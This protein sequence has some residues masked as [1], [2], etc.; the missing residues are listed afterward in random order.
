AKGGAPVRRTGHVAELLK[1]AVDL[2]RAG[3][4]VG[5]HLSIGAGLWASEFDPGQM[6]QVLH[7]IL[8]N[9]RQ[10]MPEGGVIEAFAENVTSDTSLPLAPG[11][12]VRICVRDQGHGIPPH[13]LPR[14]FDPYFTTK[15]SGSGLGLATAYAIVAKHQGHIGVE[16]E[17]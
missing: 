13:I 2:A 16:S 1:D 15:P 7:N 12:Y 5:I 9:A 3:S 6:G 10:S 17:V 8:L 4:P 14:I 11:N